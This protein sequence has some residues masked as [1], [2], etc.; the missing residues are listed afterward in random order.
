MTSEGV[1]TDS[2]WQIANVRN[3]LMAV[4]ACNDK[5]NPCWFDSEGSYILSG[6]SPEVA[7]IRQLIKDMTKKIKVERRGGTFKVKLWRMP[8]KLAEGFTRRGVR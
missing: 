7:Q 2:T 1:V 5:G 3:P 6:S 4:S 8:P